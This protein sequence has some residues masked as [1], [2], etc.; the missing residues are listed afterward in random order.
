MLRTLFIGT[1]LVGCASNKKD[2]DV[3]FC[4]ATPLD[5]AAPTDAAL[6]ALMRANE[7]RAMMNLAPGSLHPLLNQ[8][9]QAHADYMACN[10]VISH[11]E[12]AGLG[13]FTGEWVWDRID[14]AG[15]VLEG[16]RSWS[17][18]IADGYSATDAIDGWVNSVYHRIPFTMPY[19]VDV[20]F[21]L[22]DHYS[23]MTFVTPYPDGPRTAVI[24]PVDGQVGVPVDFNSDWEI[25]DPDPD[26]EIIGYPISV[27]VAAPDAGDAD[28][29]PYDLR[30]VDAALFGPDG[31]KLELV[32]IDPETDGYL[33]T[34]V[35]MWTE[36]PLAANTQYEASMTVRWDGSEQTLTT[37][38]TT[39]P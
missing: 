6:E 38:F 28:A 10:E 1:L 17:E 2:E 35:A 36:T 9:S 25:P 20:G 32:T 31:A 15:Y 34:M 11:Q 29:D 27:T 39:A 26:R 14:A 5:L 3:A 21:G 37:T 19:W 22:T 33:Y 18:V 12:D 7:H 4:P 16:G 8:A 23:A 30:L 13:G 24:Y